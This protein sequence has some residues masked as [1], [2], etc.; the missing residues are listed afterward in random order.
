M[1]IVNYL[2]RPTY[3]DTNGGGGSSI[4]S[5]GCGVLFASKAIKPTYCHRV[6]STNHKVVIMTIISFHPTAARQ[7]WTISQALN[8]SIF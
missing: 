2:S 3:G 7:T 1:S 4:G 5:D 8:V 6:T